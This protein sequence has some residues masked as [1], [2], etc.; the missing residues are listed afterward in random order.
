MLYRGKSRSSFFTP[1]SRLAGSVAQKA[2]S[3][4][5]QL[6]TFF[7]A[8][9]ATALNIAAN[10]PATLATPFSFFE[11]D[12]RPIKNNQWASAAAFEAV[13]IY[14]LIMSF[15]VAVWSNAAR[16][17][18]DW[19]KKLSFFSLLTWRIGLP[20]VTYLWISLMFSLLFIA[21]QIPMNGVTGSATGFIILWALHY[22]C[23]GA[24]G[25]TLESLMALIGPEMLPFT[26][27]LWIILNI[28]S[29]FQPLE[30]MQ[31][32]YQL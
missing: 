26:L 22:C 23:L 2:S 15:D 8:N 16:T 20:L 7:N 30:V 3:Q 24:V 25:L 5:S 13:L 12:L 32:F 14:Y 11:E 1:Q 28:T 9:N 17:K 6:W 27:I 19:S 31:Q 4:T 10:A 18:T 29:S 21:F